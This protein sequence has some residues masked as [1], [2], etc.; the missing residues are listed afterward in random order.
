M[1]E[2]ILIF[3]I[4]MLFWWFV[5]KFYLDKKYSE[6]EELEVIEENIMLGSGFS[7]IDWK[8]LEYYI[9]EKSKTEKPST[10][11]NRTYQI[12][13]NTS[14]EL[15]HNSAYNYGTF[16]N[17]GDDLY[18]ASNWIE[19]I[20]SDYFF[21]NEDDFDKVHYI[22]IANKILN[23]RDFVEES[24]PDEEGIGIG[25]LL[26]VSDIFKKCGV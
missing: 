12:I 4:W 5:Q 8:E 17:V 16:Y 10:V 13:L 9:L 3:T 1:Y 15:K 20:V 22:N 24:Y 18:K 25:S 2:F 11:C 7:G 6:Y 23:S 26:T 14:F 19:S 21:E